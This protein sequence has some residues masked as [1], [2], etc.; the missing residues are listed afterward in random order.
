MANPVTT[1]IATIQSDPFVPFFQTVMQPTDEVLVSRGG[2]SAY[3]VYDEI[4][5][6]PHAFAILQ[7]RKLE[8][9]SREWKVF[10]ASDRRI[11]K[12]IAAEV[13]LWLKAVNFDRL[14]KG[15][16]GAVLKGFAVGEIMW[17]NDEGVWKPSS[18]KVKKQR[19]FRFDMDGNLRV[20]TRS[21]P[22]DGI[23][24]PDRKFVI[25]RHSVD[26]DDD[27][28]YG[29][30]LGSVL[31]W[32]AWFKRQ[33][34]ANWLQATRKHASPTTLGQYQGGF[35]Q[36]KQ[37]QLAGVF[38]SMQGS[39][40]LIFPENVKVELLE[41]KTQGDQFATLSRYLDELMSEAV[42]GET[43]STNSG[44]R[45]ARSLGE[46]HNEVRIAIAKADADLTCQTIK[47]TAVQWYVDLNYPGE[48]V[49]DVWRD[50]SEAEDLDEKVKR[51]ETIYGMGY[52]PASVDYINDT[53]GGEWV[54]QQKIAEPNPADQQPSAA[55][56]LA[57][58]DPERPETQ[59]EKTVADL[60][61]QL[62]TL[63]RP[64]IDTMIAD[65]EAA[66]SEA[67]SYDDLAERLARLSGDMSIDDLA[68]LMAQATVAADLEGQ[69][70]GNG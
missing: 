45:G 7:K 64:A 17:I 23:A 6:D 59:S 55:A 56:G 21:S 10:E 41:A 38:A 22:V 15:L 62:A 5:R 4:R 29:V 67:T 69:A 49:P 33:V 66:F 60:S 31:F 2:A 53:Y 20:L 39:D 25:H 24:V 48:A 44:E 26:D 1:E 51:D 35:D 3:K 42:L 52:K 30:G 68:Q 9:V 65:I 54:E 11:D 14:T 36:L 57:F 18:I 40:S 13:E 34:L 28:P 63:G 27:D 12:R 58:A 70:S 37:D 46:I 47:E 50:F 61:D 8:V 19:R 16:L 43:L 32:P